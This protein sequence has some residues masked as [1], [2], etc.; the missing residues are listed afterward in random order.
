MVKLYG[1]WRSVAAHRV[2]IACHYK[3]LPFEYVAVDLERDGGA[4][5]LPGYGLLNPARAVPTLVDGDFV[6]SQSLAIIEYLEEAYPLPPLLPSKPVERAQVRSLAQ[7]MVSDCQPLLTSRVERRLAI[8][9]ESSSATPEAW[10]QHWLRQSFD[11]LEVQLE[12]TAGEYCFG[13]GLTLADLCLLPQ[14]EQAQREQL[15]LEPYRRIN[16][17]VARCRTLPCF[18]QA[19][20]EL[21]P[22]AF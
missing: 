22:D 19:A 4:H 16:Q 13:D 18:R 14:W 3:G 11:A 9:H 10:R 7:M 2:R 6:L 8:Y 5:R 21:Q 12:R 1:Y 15:M 20:P 17:I